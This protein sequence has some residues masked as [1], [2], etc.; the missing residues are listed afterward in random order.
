MMKARSRIRCWSFF[1]LAVGLFTAARAAQDDFVTIDIPGS[2]DVEAYGIDNHGT[3]TGL[4]YDAAG[5]T[6]GFVYD[7]GVLTTVDGPTSTPP[8]SQAQLYN[9]DNKEQVGGTYVDDF[10]N[11]RAAVYDL[12]AQSWSALPIIP[13][14]TYNASGGLN[15]RGV[16][17]GNWTADPSGATGFQGWLYDS[18]SGN[19][20]YFDVPG[21]DKVNSYGT[22]VNDINNA[23]LVVGWY[24]DGNGGIHGFTKQGTQ[25][26]TIDVPGALNTQLFGINSQGDLAGRYRVGDTRHGFILR[27]NGTLITIDVPGAINTWVEA[28]SENGNIAGFYETADGEYHAFFAL[29]AVH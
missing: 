17:V 4:Y 7:D 8:L 27:N 9:I 26:Q 21:S 6:H 24:S 20:T 22:I 10:G 1:A 29:K 28:I 15:A 12:K 25:Y 11:A 3:V 18:H 16:V 23:G 14:A 19:Y 2:A 5:N 13:G